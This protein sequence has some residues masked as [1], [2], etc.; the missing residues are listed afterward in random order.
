[1]RLFGQQVVNTFSYFLGPSSLNGN[2]LN[3]LANT[4]TTAW[5]ANLMPRLSGELVLLGC[6]VYA[7]D[8]SNA[9]VG[10]FTRATALPGGTNAP[11]LPGNVAFCIKF[12]SGG[13]GRTTR[14]RIFL[15]GLPETIVNGNTV[16][17]AEADQILSG[18]GLFRGATAAAGAEHII[19]SR[20][21]NGT[22]RPVGTIRAVTSASY[23]DLF[24]DSQRRRLTGRG[25]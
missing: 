21:I 16:S 25:I 20:F 24:V 1:M 4:I 12:G 14:G 19:I 8:A 10:T 11:S 6:T 18:I 2:V 5:G 13:R 9:P 23:S 17:L 3:N 15:A 22:K 7:L